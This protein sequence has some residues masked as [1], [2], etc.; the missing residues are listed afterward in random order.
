MAKRRKFR[1]AP[2]AER[3]MQEHQAELERIFHSDQDTLGKLQR[4]HELFKNTQAQ[5]WDL[6]QYG[7]VSLDV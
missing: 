7:S 6:R 3:V 5:L 2:K 1:L 4:A